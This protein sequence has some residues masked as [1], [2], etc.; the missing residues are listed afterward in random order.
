MI[1]GGGDGGGEFS[2]PRASVTCDWGV[3]P[4]LSK[5]EHERGSFQSIRMST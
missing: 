4:L 3:S 2:W 5:C 1:I